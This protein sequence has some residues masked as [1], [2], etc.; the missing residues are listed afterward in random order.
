MRAPGWPARLTD[1][2]VG[3]RPLRL[4][5]AVTWV[6]IRVRNGEW[7]GPWEATPKAM[8]VT[9]DAWAQRQTIGVY[10]RMVRR[11]RQQARLGTALPFAVT[12]QGRLVGQVTVSTIV[13]GALNS[14]HLGYWVDRGYAGRGITP[15]AVALVVDHCF[16]AAAL[17]RVEAYVRPENT[18]S[19]RVVEKLGFREE[20]LHRRYLAIGGTYRDHIS[21]AITLEDAPEGLLNRWRGSRASRS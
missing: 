5:E 13:R 9:A 10:S 3:V 8:P 20:G 15:T 2:S 11:L 17:H 4:R 14:G 1:G 16:T 18:A 12:F 21:Y 7:L 19:R 6:E